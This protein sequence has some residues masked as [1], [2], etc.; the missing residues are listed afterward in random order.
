M[1]ISRHGFVGVRSHV[2]STGSCEA[3]LPRES[4]KAV[5][6]GL[7]ELAVQR[8][9]RTE[10]TKGRRIKVRSTGGASYLASNILASPRVCLQTCAIREGT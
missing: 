1:R 2:A 10:A 3:V 4:L 5:A 8:Q 9:G 7:I 6:L